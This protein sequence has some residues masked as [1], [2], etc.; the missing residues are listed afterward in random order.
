MIAS[1]RWATPNGT[2][3]RRTVPEAGSIRTQNGGHR[4]S[5]AVN[6]DGDTTTR[7]ALERQDGSSLARS[8]TTRTSTGPK[9]DAGASINCRHP[10]QSSLA[11]IINVRASNT[12]VTDAPSSVAPRQSRGA[13]RPPPPSMERSNYSD[14][15]SSD[16]TSRP[17][18]H[19]RHVTSST[20][21]RTTCGSSMVRSP[22]IE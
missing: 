22:P 6:S 20:T 18:P 3:S 15:P 12:P 11:A 14:V 8:T 5:R 13:G 19:H 9:A 17:W 10:S 2:P 7:W 1:R 21:R 4:T 16:V